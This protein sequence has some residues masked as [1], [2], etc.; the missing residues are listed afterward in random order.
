MKKNYLFT[1]ALFLWNTALFSQ[2]VLFEDNFDSYTAGQYLAAQSSAWTTWS[3]TS[4]GSDDALVT[5]DQALSPPNSVVVQGETDLVLPLGDK[6][7]GQFDVCFNIYIETGCGGYYNYLHEFKGSATLYW[8]IDIYFREDG[9]GYIINNY[10]Q[11]A[12]F[13]YTKNAWVECKLTVDL[14]EDVAEL[15][16]NGSFVHTWQWSLDGLKQLG[17]VDFWAFAP[18]GTP[19]YYIDNVSYC[20]MTTG[21]DEEKLDYSPEGYILYDNYPNPFNNVT[22]IGYYL[23]KSAEVILVIYDLKGT[24]VIR[25][26]QGMQTAGKHSVLWNGQNDLG[27]IVA[28]G[29]Y[30]YRIEAK[31]KEKTF[32]DVKKMIF[33]K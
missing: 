29:M 28:S 23:L 3:Q 22:T 13:T 33:M 4:G 7:E 16:I 24:E 25:Y 27:N 8:A 26:V 10:A 18:N 30:F 2:T 1:A 21:V 9:T 12:S 15:Y 19:K 14:D 31:T 32:V 11:V 20:D 17:A 5:T 6:T